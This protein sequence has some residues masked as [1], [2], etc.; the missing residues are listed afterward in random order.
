MGYT[1][2]MENRAQRTMLKRA[3]EASW[4]ASNCGGMVFLPLTMAMKEGEANKEAVL[5][6]IDNWIESWQGVRHLSDR[7]LNRNREYYTV[8][9]NVLLSPILSR[10]EVEL[11]T[12][13]NSPNIDAELML[14]QVNELFLGTAHE[15]HEF[16]EWAKSAGASL[17]FDAA[18]YEAE[19]VSRGQKYWAKTVRELTEMMG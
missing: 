6:L 8:R 2:F 12:L 10:F 11:T 7:N 3:M 16:T 19:A 14:T 13:R 18:K 4:T 5:G 17:G 9:P 1:S 15:L